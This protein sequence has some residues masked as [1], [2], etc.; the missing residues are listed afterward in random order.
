[1]RSSA[2]GEDPYGRRKLCSERGEIVFVGTQD[3][4]A[5]RAGDQDDVGVDD[6]RRTGRTT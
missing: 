1:M 4:R 6:I 5:A 3:A 2:D